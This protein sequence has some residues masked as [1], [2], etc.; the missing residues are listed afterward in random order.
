M[1][2]HA[3]LIA[4]ASLLLPPS[5]QAAGAPILT[6]EQALATVD[7]PHP[8]WQ[9]ATAGHA[10]AEADRALAESRSDWS[11]NLTAGLRYGDP[12]VEPAQ[13]SDNEIRLSARKSLYDFGRTEYAGRAASSLVESRAAL[14]TD[15]RTQRRLDIMSIYFEV[16]LTDMQYAAENEYTAV[17]YVSFDHAKARQS[18]GQISTTELAALEKK[19]QDWRVK[20]NA[21]QLR[22]RASRARLANAM[23][24]P[25]KLASELED[26]PLAGNDRLL[27]EHETLLPLLQ[28]KNPRLLA[29]RAQL[30][31]ARERIEAIRSEKSPTIDFE[32]EAGDYSRIA[33]TR[34][35][36]KAG[37]VLNWPL[38]Q[39]GRV[40]SLLAK[41]QAQFQSLQAQ[42]EKLKMELEQT[43]LETWLEIGDLQQSV[44][45][46]AKQNAEYRDLALERARGEYEVELKT[47]LGDAMAATMDARLQL[48]RA[49]YRLSL[50]FARLEGLLGGA[51]Y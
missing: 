29:L 31:A 12:T 47:D 20:R 30:Q 8:D 26:P 51:L 16:L 37:V 1:K 17:A 15:A 34:D 23:N 50:A 5:L 25:G 28:E 6:L 32:M 2:S 48:R 33:L 14:L 11:M 38:Y 3:L 36:V 41:E 42:S 9:L 10:L 40:D 45:A 46:A 21:S 49:E 27:P 18:L 24:Q 7:A 43:L 35:K 19:Y 4:L 39:G 13:N 22:Q 44:R